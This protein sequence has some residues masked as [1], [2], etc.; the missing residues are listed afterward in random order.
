MTVLTVHAQYR[1]PESKVGVPIQGHVQRSAT[2]GVGVNHW[3]ML[4]RDTPKLSMEVAQTSTERYTNR[5]C[6]CEVRPV[7]ICSIKIV[8]RQ[9]CESFPKLHM[10]VTLYS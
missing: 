4:L 1:N 10:N 3:A 5:L 2:H 9:P 8:V 6:Y 7:G